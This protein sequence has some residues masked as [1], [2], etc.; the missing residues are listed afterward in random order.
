MPRRSWSPVTPGDQREPGHLGA[1]GLRV[2]GRACRLERVRDPVGGCL[3]VLAAAQPGEQVQHVL[4]LLLPP[5]QHLRQV[6]HLPQRQAPER[7]YGVCAACS[8]RAQASASSTTVTSPPASEMTRATC[9]S[10]ADGP[11]EEDERGRVGRAVSA[12]MVTPT[13]SLMPLR[14]AT[15]V[16]SGVF[17]LRTCHLNR[18]YSWLPK[19]SCRN[20]LIIATPCGLLVS[21]VDIASSA[22]S[23]LSSMSSWPRHRNRSPSRVNSMP[24]SGFGSGS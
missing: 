12:S 10:V 2:A 3:V 13:A 1:P 9:P 19:A 16:S 11:G 14:M 8:P 7:R 22:S 23:L 21:V 18:R 4:R 6:A 5:P 17:S 24:S 20:W 15:T